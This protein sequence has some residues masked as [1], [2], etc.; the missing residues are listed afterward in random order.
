VVLPQVALA[1]LDGDRPEEADDVMATSSDQLG[2]L[3]RQ[4]CPSGVDGDGRGRSLGEPCGSLA[5]AR[6]AHIVRIEAPER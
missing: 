1:L 4:G 6:V 3:G 5:A 2:P